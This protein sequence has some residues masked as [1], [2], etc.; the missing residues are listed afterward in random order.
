MNSSLVTCGLDENDNADTLLWRKHR[1]KN[2]V[3]FHASLAVGITIAIGLIQALVQAEPVTMKDNNPK[4]L[5]MALVNIRAEYS[6]TADPAA[7]KKIIQ[8]NIDRHMYFVDKLAAEGAE[9]IGFPEASIN[10][11]HYSG[12]MTWL[13]RSG[14][15]VKVFQQKA[16]EKGIYISAGLAEVDEAGKKWETQFVVD[17]QGNIIAWYHKI[18]LTGERGYIEQ[19]NEHPVFE[20][21]GTKM[22]I[23]ICADGSDFTNLKA[24]ADKGAKIIYAPHCNSTGST[25]AGWYQFRSRWAGKANESKVTMKAGTAGVDTEMPAGGWVDILNVY[26]ALHNHAGIYNEE[27]S[28]PPGEHSKERWASGAWFIDPDGE[29]LAQMPVSYDRNDSTEYVL[30]YNIPLD[31]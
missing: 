29:T 3:I 12:N 16:K 6:D 8:A 26:A 13:S 2:G 25:T 20:V 9:F 30:T 22:G 18:W 17:P 11:Y 7:N 24:L 14:P 10:G 5:K 31:K 21:K 15:E 1:V 28:P 19:G 27:Y 4:H 23:A